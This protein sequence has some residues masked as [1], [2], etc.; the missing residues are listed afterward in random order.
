M[1][2][3]TPADLSDKRAPL[4]RTNT[5]GDNDDEEFLIASFTNI[6][7]Y[8][9]S[10]STNDD[11]DAELQPLQYSGSTGALFVTTCRILWLDA[12][13]PVGYGWEMSAVTLHAI[14]RDPAAFPKPCVYCQISDQDVSEV[15][16]VPEDDKT[17]T[18]FQL[19]R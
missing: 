18:C 1:N 9:S 12:E 19:L 5:D 3:L 7:L 16:F 2:I 11:N 4:L 8:A 6:E 10:S 17:C 15:R 13:Q 14:S